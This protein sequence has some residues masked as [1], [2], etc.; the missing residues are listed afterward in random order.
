MK[1]I[2]NWFW[3]L[4]FHKLPFRYKLFTAKIF[5]RMFRGFGKTYYDDLI[6]YNELSA[7][8]ETKGKPT[9]TMMQGGDK[10]KDLREKTRIHN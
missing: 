10:A 5:I 1:K 7:W 2:I 9:T 8:I 6:L 4:P 3:K